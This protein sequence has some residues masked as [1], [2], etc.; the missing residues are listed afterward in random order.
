MYV[1]MYVCMYVRTYVCMYVCPNIFPIWRFPT[2][3][4]IPNPRSLGCPGGPTAAQRPRKNHLDPEPGGKTWTSWEISWDLLG[5]FIVRF[6]DFNENLGQMLI[7]VNQ[8]VKEVESLVCSISFWPI[9]LG[10]RWSLFKIL[11]YYVYITNLPVAFKVYHSQSWV[12]YDI[13]LPTLLPFDIYIFLYISL[14]QTQP[15]ITN[16]TPDSHML[17]LNYPSK[18]DLVSVFPVFSYGFSILKPPYVY[19]FIAFTSPRF[20]SAKAKNHWTTHNSQFASRCW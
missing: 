12:V 10:F 4:I 3:Q 6:A 13:F 11:T 14:C 5:I 16:D 2:P 17:G 19:I 8:I 18:I 9:Q 7:K 1:C 20:K 15:D